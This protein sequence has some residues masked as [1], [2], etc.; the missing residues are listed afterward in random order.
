MNQNRTLIIGAVIAAIV[1]VP[2][3]VVWSSYNG[4][5]T[6]EINVDNEW[7]QVEVQYQRRFD[8]IP[9]VVN[10]TKLYINY[11]QKLLTDIASAR[12]GWTDSLGGS[13]NDQVEAAGEMDSVFNRLLA[14]MVVE[15]YPELQGNTLVLGLIDELEGTEN[16]IAVARLRYNEAV[17]EYNKKV[18]LFPGSIVA[19]MF[20]FEQRDYYESQD[21]SDL[22]PNVPI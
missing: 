10:S 3:L 6:A 12:S 8:L 18:R 9:R 1:I 2:L 14:I 13:V 7:A 20:G 16:R 22:A 5:V 17:T 4:L 21:G 15:D 11:E 19:G